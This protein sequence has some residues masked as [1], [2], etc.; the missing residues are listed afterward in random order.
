LENDQF[1][2]VRRKLKSLLGYLDELG[3]NLPLYE[4]DYLS[5]ELMYKR[6]VERTC[7]IAIECTI[8]ANSMLI[9]IIGKAP[10]ESARESFEVAHQLGIIDSDTLRRFHES[11]VG[12]RNRL[13]HVYEQVNHRIV[14]HTARLLIDYGK[15]YVENLTAYLEQQQKE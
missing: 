7:Q 14:F 5:A 10:P 13:V 2:P 4:A 9:S 11:F 3:G 8:D 1:D 15:R 12:F 6:G